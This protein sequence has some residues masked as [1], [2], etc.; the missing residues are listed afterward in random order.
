MFCFVFSAGTGTQ[1]LV[2]AQQ[3]LCLELRPSALLYC[4]KNWSLSFK[5]IK[6]LLGKS[7][8]LRV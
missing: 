6:W 8:A 2:D 3:T 7:V 5:G 1:D 4:G